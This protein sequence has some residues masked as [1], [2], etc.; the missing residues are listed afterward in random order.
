VLVAGPTVLAFLSGGFFDKPR[1]VAGVLAW[2]LVALAAIA[3]PSPIPR[4][5]AA[6][7]AAAGLALLTAWTGLSLF[8]APLS[9]R[10]TDDLQRLLLYLGAFLAAAAYLCERRLAR[11]AEAGLA[12][13]A[14]VVAAYALAGRL[15]PETIEPDVSLSAFGRL[16]QPLTYW[17]ALGGLAA[18]GLVLCARLAG[19]AL[20]PLALR[21]VAGA[22]AGPLGAAL[23]LTYSRGA[24]VALATGVVLLALLAPGRAEARGIAGA[25]LAAALGAL[26]VAFFGDVASPPDPPARA[27]DSPAALLALLVAC[28]AGAALCRWQAR[29]P[30]AASAASARRPPGRWLA[31][32]VGGLAAASVGAVLAVAL[33]STERAVV[34][35]PTGADPGR[36]GTL[37]SERYEYWRVAMRAFGDDPLLGS[38][39][40]GFR[41]EWRAEAP[42][43][44][45]A[46]A[47]AH[48]LYVETVSELGLV[49][50]AALGLFAGGMVAAAAGAWRLDP[51]LSTGPAALAGA[52]AVHAGLDWDWEMPAFTL[53]A[54]VAMGLLAAASAE[55]PGPSRAPAP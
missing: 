16:E 45:P 30:A 41:A 33:L 44:A 25:L 5:R 29:R 47:D 21:T 49:G 48:S 20:R 4:G 15:L 28:G 54:L 42:R 40:G 55:R 46:A 43:D 14:F 19:D 51:A 24:Y 17:N 34:E 52:W 2:L 23:Y 6:R 31:L 32:G 35:P 36:L 27:G 7:W 11:M 37:E 3:L 1:L 18:I 8:W 22:A 53:V 50:L 38:G 13:G 12:L 10:A 26:S 9:D 39:S